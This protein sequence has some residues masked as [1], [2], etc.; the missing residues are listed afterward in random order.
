MKVIGQGSD[1]TGAALYGDD[2]GS[3][4]TGLE[5]GDRLGEAAATLEA[6]AVEGTGEGTGSSQL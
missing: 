3:A 1:R 5:T 6:R 4:G 2:T